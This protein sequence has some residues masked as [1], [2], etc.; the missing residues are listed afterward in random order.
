[1]ATPTKPKPFKG[2]T[3]AQPDGTMGRSVCWSIDQAETSLA[4]ACNG[5]R[6]DKNYSSLSCSMPADL[7]WAKANGWQLVKVRVLVVGI[8][9][10]V[11]AKP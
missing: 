11:K 10:D 9:R 5:T 7:E 2:Y 4:M 1:M 6:A 8:V 3:Y